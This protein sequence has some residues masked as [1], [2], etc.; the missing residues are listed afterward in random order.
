MGSEILL[1][2]ELLQ[3]ANNFLE[4]Q[5]VVAEEGSDELSSEDRFLLGLAEKIEPIEY[6][7]I[8]DLAGFFPKQEEAREKADANLFTLFGGT[9]GP[10]KS[11]FLRWYGLYLLEKVYKEFGISGARIML[12][13]ETY[14]TLYERHL[15]KVER[16][17]FGLG[18]YQKV[19]REFQL[20]PEYGSGVL[21]FRNLDDVEKYAGSEYLTILVDELTRNRKKVFD[22]LRGSIRWPG[23]TDEWLRFVSA[24]MPTGIGKVWVRE[25]FLEKKL[26]EEMLGLED[27]IVY[28]FGSPTDNPHLPAGYWAM[29]KTLPTP[30]RKA[31]L[32]GDWYV[33]FEGL[34][35][36]EFSGEN[37]LEPEWEPALDEEGLPIYEVELGYDDG[38][39]DP[40]AILFIQ[41]T[42][43][44]IFVFD[45]IYIRRELPE[46]SIRR[47]LDRMIS[48]FGS[49]ADDDGEPALDE[50]GEEIPIVMPAI[51]VG[52]PEAAVLKKRFRSANIPIRRPGIKNV[53]EGISHVRELI[54]DGQG[55]R[56]IKIHP[57]CS[58]LISEL[59]EGYIYPEEGTRRDDEKPLDGNDHAC[60]ALRYWATARIKKR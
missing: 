15:V 12:A 14:P 29:L 39:I 27:K 1:D 30:L 36:S 43:T 46:R 47:I 16:E 60:E 18:N 48:H 28:V 26:P 20:S 53:V 7:P 45:E 38:Y 24:S 59:T 13:C 23:V 6:T 34:V 51:A 50:H 40:R 5:W 42:G 19:L 21:A 22:V 58:N 10:G 44:E 55:V 11:Y 25:M 31:W 41:K 57:R 35:Y 56:T 52:S 54:I 9:R 2:D 4:Y 33:S 37:L 3:T 8:L 17:F 32:E 49:E